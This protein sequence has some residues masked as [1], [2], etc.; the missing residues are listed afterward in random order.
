MTYYLLCWGYRK[1][2][3]HL[4][5]TKRCVNKSNEKISSRLYAGIPFRGRHS[6]FDYSF[7]FKLQSYSRF[8]LR[9]ISLIWLNVGGE[10]KYIKY[11]LL[12]FKV[13]SDQCNH[14]LFRV[15]FYDY[16]L[17]SLLYTCPFSK[18]LTKLLKING[19]FIFKSWL[20]RVYTWHVYK[21][22]S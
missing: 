16:W 13:M 20:I 19:P 14:F 11:C 6:S 9:I 22:N 18:K 8:E 7:T 10:I 21:N 4:G 3:C 15:W 12:H 2:V 17:V 5:R 1:F